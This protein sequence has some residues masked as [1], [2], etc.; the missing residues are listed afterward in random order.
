MAK[1]GP[2]DGIR[3][4]ELTNWMAGPSAAAA[5]A[6]M[7]A[8]VIK[9]EP[10]TGDTARKMSRPTRLHPDGAEIDAGFQ[11]DNRGKRSVA[12][13]IDKPEGAAVVRRLV[14]GAH[15]LLCNLL[16]QRQAKFGLDPATL[17]A[18]RPGLVHATLTGYGLGGPDA[19][20]PGFDVT[21]FFGRGAITESLTDVGAQAPQPRPAQ[22]D[23]TTALALIAA[24]LAALRVAERTGEGQIVDVSLMA[25]ATWTMATDLAPVLVDGREPS[26][27]DRDHR[28]AALATSHRCSDDRFIILNMTEPRWWP[29]LCE[30]LEHPEWT[31]DERFDTPRNRLRNMPELTRLLDAVFVTRPMLEWGRLF[32]ESGLIWG[33]ASTLGELALDE[34]AAAAGLFPEITVAEGTIR[35]IAVP[36]RIDGA[37]IRPR[38]PA[39]AIGEHTLEVLR[40]VGMDDGEISALD[41]AGV[42][43]FAPATQF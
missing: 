30:R 11:M 6:D 9:V 43:V 37:D 38:G 19:S 28:L 21:A 33:P 27:R 26:K 20:R 1:V 10:P 32:D 2:L 22:G 24:V 34:Q 36:I 16:P 3:V 7:G 42:I 25:A 29:R 8:D 31:D 15:V 39:P 35:T 18:I 14:A 12:I 4:V 13:A 5:L 41:A 23:H 17:F 40:E